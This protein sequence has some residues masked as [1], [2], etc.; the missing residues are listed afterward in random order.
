MAI[1]R[2]EFLV[3]AAGA[4]A[5]V[6]LV[7]EAFPAAVRPRNG[8]VSVGLIGCGRQGRKI[9]IE[10][11]DKMGE[12][13][14]LVALCDPVERLT[15]N[16]QGRAKGAAAFASHKELLDKAK[17]VQAV[18][19]ATPTHTHK[20][21][22][23]DCLAAGKHVYC[24]A[25]LAHTPEDCLA[26][27]KAARGSKT[28]FASACEGRSNPIYSLARSFFKTDAVRTAVGMYAQD[29]RKSTWGRAGDWWLDPSVSTG[30]AGESGVQQFDV[31]HWFRGS[32][33]VEVSGRGTIRL[34]EDGRQV[35]DTVH[36]ALRWADGTELAY[37][38]TLCNSFGGK[39]ETLYG[40]NAAIK[41]AW[42]HGWMFKEADSPQLG[43]EVYANRQSFHNDEGITLI[44]DATK[45]A[46]QGKLKEGVGLPNP[47]HYYAVNDF[48]ASVAEGKEV[49][50]S[51]SEGARATIVALMTNEAIKSGKTVTID[52]EMLKGA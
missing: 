43:F 44:A 4:A 29:H 28:V 23:L 5:A 26:I 27:A 41:L 38:A 47:S 24:E 49:K 13:A 11:L 37:S 46:S 9:A 48:I 18:I 15:Q 31:M 33:P 17:D 12:G 25:P 10:M 3:R 2:R 14:N 42:S 8:P 1:D 34:H 7:P 30:L 39:H 50:C 36:A 22:A 35:A 6:A 16:L 20:E 52:A 32:Y 51:A 40:V 21:I 19:V 45:L